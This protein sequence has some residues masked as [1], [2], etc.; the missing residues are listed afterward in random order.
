MTSIRHPATTSTRH[1][2]YPDYFDLRDSGT[3]ASLAAY[4]PVS[5]T[6][7]AN[8]QPEPLAG[9]LVSGNYFE[10]LGVRIPIR[11][12]VHARRRSTRGARSRG[13][14]L[15]CALAARVQRRPIVDRPDDPSQQQPVHAHRCRT[16]RVR[17]SAPRSRDGRLGSHSASARSG[18]AGGGCAALARSFGDL[19]PAPFERIEHG[20][21]A[22]AWRQHRRRWRRAPKSFPAASR[23]RTRIRT[24]TGG[25]RVA[26]LG[27]GRGLRVATRPMLRQ[28]AG[29]VL[30]VLLV[31]C[32]NVASLLLARAVSREREVAVRIAIGASRAQARPS[33]AHRIRAPRD[34][35]L[36]RG[37]ARRSRQHA[38]AP[39]LRDSGG[40][41]PLGER[42][43]PRLHARR[44]CWK[45]AAL[46]ARARS[47]RRSGGIR[48]RHFGRE[49]PLRPVPA[50]AGCAVRSS[51]FRSP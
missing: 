14:H 37:A 43:R 12:R 4:T 25:S 15:A 27:E 50:P 48:P 51:S 29:A 26:P 39:H 46:R 13:G 3:F 41:R 9:Q 16:T 7:D 28:L 23:P 40:C 22:A 20:G 2:S 44:W 17:R 21:P 42:A 11:S 34:P 6:M 1:S 36:D 49:A 47:F 18:S 5:I 8:G 10:V 32:V 19:R 35:G 33:M 30:M 24:A 31:A 38:A 45:R